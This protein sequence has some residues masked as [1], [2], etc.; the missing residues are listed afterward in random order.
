MREHS[1]AQVIGGS[2][3][4][5][6]PG[7]YTWLRLELSVAILA[8]DYTLQPADHRHGWSAPLLS[9]ALGAAAFFVTYL[10]S[11]RLT[12]LIYRATPKAQASP[13]AL[14]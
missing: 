14:R 7:R 13:L 3:R 12:Y 11:W 10:S 1:A 5:Q 6:Y 8:S 2:N 4:V 9:R